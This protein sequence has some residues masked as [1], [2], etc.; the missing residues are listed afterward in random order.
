MPRGG[1]RKG[2][3]RPIGSFEDKTLRRRAVKKAID[4]RVMKHADKLFHAQLG[5]AVGILFPACPIL[6]PG[7]QQAMSHQSSAI[8]V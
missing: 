4:E 2:A 7:L 1:K 8:R 5:K 6:V 3:G